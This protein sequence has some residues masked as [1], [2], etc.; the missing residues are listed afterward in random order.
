MLDN[1]T[2]DSTTYPN[3]GTITSYLNYMLSQKSET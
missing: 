3:T 2:D 1:A